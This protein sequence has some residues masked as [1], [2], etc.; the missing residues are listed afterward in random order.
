ML[1]F[2]DTS[3]QPL[4]FY[5]HDDPDAFRMELGGGLSGAAAESAYHAWHTALSTLQGRPVVVN[6]SFV[7][8]MDE[9]GRDVLLRWH[10]E[11]TRIV[12]RSP[13]SR[14]LAGGI[15]SEPAPL[16]PPRKNLRRRLTSMLCRAKMSLGI[17]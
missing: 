17:R 1:Q 16:S 12:A 3:S 9:A 5:L 7:N 8:Q 10:K 6:I 13:E 15:A 2:T 14:A 4:R 11:G